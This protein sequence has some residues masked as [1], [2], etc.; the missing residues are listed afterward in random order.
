M[1]HPSQD[2]DRN[3]YSPLLCIAVFL[4]FGAAT[5]VNGLAGWF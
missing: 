5:Q 3:P 2:N 1:Q 4:M